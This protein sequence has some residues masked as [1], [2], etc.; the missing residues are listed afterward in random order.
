M[1]VV[2][3]L[4]QGRT[5]AAQ[6][7]LFT[8]KSVPV[9]FEPPGILIFKFLDNNLEDKRFCTQTAQEDEYLQMRVEHIIETL[10]VI[11]AFVLCCCLSKYIRRK[12]KRVRPMI[13][14]WP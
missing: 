1:E 7:G 3:A 13:F 12:L 8:H 10:D 4:S 5:A 6:C 2:A 11:L 9:I 14:S